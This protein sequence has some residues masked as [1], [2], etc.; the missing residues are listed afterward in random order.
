M[1]ED[2]RYTGPATRQIDQM[3][4]VFQEQVARLEGAETPSDVDV[5]TGL[6]LW[7]AIRALARH[8]DMLGQRVDTVRAA[9]RER[10]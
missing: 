4:A 8:I 2:T 1:S 7:E 5:L 9:A 10:P 6:S 3:F